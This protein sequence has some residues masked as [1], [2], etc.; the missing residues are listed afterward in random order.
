M[1]KFSIF[2]VSASL[3]L[4]AG[5]IA[6]NPT[7]DD[8]ANK[9]RQ[10]ATEESLASIR[11]RRIEHCRGRRVGVGHRRHYLTIWQSRRCRAGGTASRP[12]A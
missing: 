10:A 9:V 7:L 4:S 8:L 5:A 6:Q 12:V 11:D 3:V 2:L 1:K